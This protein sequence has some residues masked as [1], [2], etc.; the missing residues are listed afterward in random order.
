MSKV[1]SFGAGPVLLAAAFTLASPAARAED[2]ALDTIDVASPSPIAAAPAGGAGAGGAFPV[3]VLPVVTTT[4]SPVTVVT[5]GEIA[6]QQP[7]TLGD[8]LFDR[9]GLSATTYAPGGA[10]RPIIRGLDT[11]R[12]RIQEN[13]IG[14]QDVSDLGEDHAVPINPLVANRIEVIRG[15][16]SLRYGSQA[17]GGVVSVEDNRIPTLPRRTDSPGG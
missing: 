12:V 10:S 14:V 17:I 4:F 15:P 11:G 1:G 5:Q 16:A 7:R 8:A 9:P 2:I 3:G 13:G 6:R